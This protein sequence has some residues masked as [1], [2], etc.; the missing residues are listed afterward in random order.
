MFFFFFNLIN[1]TFIVWYSTSHPW[2][3]KMTYLFFW[4]SDH[5]EREVLHFSEGKTHFNSSSWRVLTYLNNIKYSVCTYEFKIIMYK[6]WTILIYICIEMVSKI[7]SN[8]TITDGPIWIIFFFLYLSL[9]E[10]SSCGRKN[11]KF[12]L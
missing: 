4:P 12:K 8:P 2:R 3:D 10:E 1:S 6:H 7:Y 5:I 9:L 11:W